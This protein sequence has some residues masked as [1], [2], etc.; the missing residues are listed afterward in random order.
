METLD[1]N[2]PAGRVHRTLYSS[3]PPAHV[4]NVEITRNSISTVRSRVFDKPY[5]HVPSAEEV[6]RYYM[7]VDT[8][9]DGHNL[10]STDDEE[11]PREQ[12]RATNEKGEDELEAIRQANEAAAA[13]MDVTTTIPS[14]GF[15]KFANNWGDTFPVVAGWLCDLCR[16][17]NPES[18]HQCMTC[19]KDR[20]VC[21]NAIETEVTAEQQESFGAAA[22]TTTTSANDHVLG[23]SASSNAQA[24][25]NTSQGGVLFTGTDSI[26]PEGFHF[27]ASTNMTDSS[28]A[29]PTSGSASGSS[30]PALS[31]GP[32]NGL[33]FGSSSAPGPANTQHG[34]NGN[35]SNASAPSMR[36]KSL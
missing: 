30:A 3:R 4:D 13:N 8:M 25:P 18:A 33:L 26:G 27:G 28:R 31:N 11:T 10:E 23:S 7:Y 17:L 14:E 32:A 24:P 29:A 22:T 2:P 15:D 16:T 5:V 1:P 34:R 35:G 19:N 20:P 6:D 12:H 21:D 36:G 9:D